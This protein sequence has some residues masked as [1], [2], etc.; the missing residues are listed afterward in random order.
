[1]RKEL[2]EIV[3]SIKKYGDRNIYYMDGLKLYGEEFFKYM[4]DGIHPYAEG[5]EPFAEQFIKEVFNKLPKEV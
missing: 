3:E 4:P 1:M 5:K 2:F